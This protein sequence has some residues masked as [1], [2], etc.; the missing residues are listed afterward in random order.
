[1]SDPV[2]LKEYKKLYPVFKDVPDSEF[3]FHNGQWLVSMR[4]VKQ[5]AYKHKNKEFIKFI[6]EVEGKLNGSNGN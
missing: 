5:L 6:N 4:A 1:M 2:D 3:T